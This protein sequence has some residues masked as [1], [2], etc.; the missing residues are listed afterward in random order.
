MNILHTVRLMSS[1]WHQEVDN[2]GRTYY[3]HVPTG[4]TQWEK[5]SSAD[6]SW[7][8]LAFGKTSSNNNIHNLVGSLSA[9]SYS[10]EQRSD[11]GVSWVKLKNCPQ[12]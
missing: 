3:V 1:S 12:T 2:E 8:Q 11:I 5:P 4:Q 7:T 10:S 9:R 6:M